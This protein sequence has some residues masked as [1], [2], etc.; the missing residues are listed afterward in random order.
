MTT[1][2]VRV[3]APHVFAPRPRVVER[4]VAWACFAAIA[5]LAALAALGVGQ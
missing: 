5:V 3:L 4:R 2:L 1:R